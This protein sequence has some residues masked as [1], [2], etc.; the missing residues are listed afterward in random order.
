MVQREECRKSYGSKNCDE[1][2]DEICGVVCLREIRE[3]NVGSAWAIQGTHP[4]RVD[5]TLDNTHHC[6]NSL[7]PIDQKHLL[8][9]LGGLS[10]ESRQEEAYDHD[11]QK[12]K[13][14]LAVHGLTRAVRILTAC[15]RF[16]LLCP[17]P[18]AFWKADNNPTFLEPLKFIE[19][20]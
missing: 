10:P 2:T 15:G 11:S 20:E 6:L 17:D 4:T 19:D 3:F 5:T 7:W 13:C 1:S 9:G 14:D 18:T 16:V 8:R 12:E